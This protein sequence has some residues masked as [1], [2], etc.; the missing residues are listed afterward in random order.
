MYDGNDD[1][2]LL[3]HQPTKTHFFQCNFS[4]NSRHIFFLIYL[5]IHC[6]SV[7]VH[8]SVFDV[9]YAYAYLKFNII[10]YLSYSNFQPF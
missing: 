10:S 9:Y 1:D 4:L 6:L 8:S 2:A 5:F 3:A 7:C